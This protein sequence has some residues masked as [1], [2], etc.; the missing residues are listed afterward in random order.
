M[1]ELARKNLLG[2]KLNAMKRVHPGLY[3]FFPITW[4]LPEM[5]GDF[6][7]YALLQKKKG[8]IFIAKPENMCQGKGIFLTNK[9]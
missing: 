8:E 1:E 9:V 6:R 5:Y 3:N 4:M 7:R 2:Y